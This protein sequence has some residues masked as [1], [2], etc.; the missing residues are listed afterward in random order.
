MPPEGLFVLF[1]IFSRALLLI[2]AAATLFAQEPALDYVFF[3]E[4]VQPIF[5]AKRNGHA[6]CVTCHTHRSPPLQEL[7]PGAE[8]WNDEQSRLNFAAWSQFVVPGKPTESRMLLHPLSAEAGGDVFHA[9]GKHWA[10]QG[11]PEWQTLASWVRGQVFGGLA[12]PS[13]TGVV[14]VL[15][16][17][18]AGDN[19]HVI[20][21]ETNTV[22]G[23]I[24]G[25]E[26]PHGIAIAPDGKR[27]YVTNEAR[28]TLDV[29]D[30]RTLKVFKQIP[31]SGH[32]NNVA[33]TP[34]GAKVYVAI[35]EE[36][37]GAVDVIDAVS[38]TNINRVATD[39][40]IHNVYVTPDGAQVFAGSIQT[41]VIN[42]IDVERDSIAWTIKMDAGI[43]PMAFTKNGD[44]STREIFVQLSDFHGF[45]IIDFSTRK[46]VRRVE[47]PDP[48]GMERET[49]GLQGSPS[50]GLAITPDQNIV[51]AT[52]K[53][54]HS[55]VA[56]SPPN[57]QCFPGRPI[58][59][60]Q[61][62]DY[63]VL[64]VIDVGSH[65]DW[66]TI[67]PDGKSLYVGVA[68]EDVTAVIDIEKLEVVAKIP[69]G[70]VP[71]RLVAGELSSR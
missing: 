29:V 55:V 30:S 3:K 65:P 2:L 43:R 28:M 4:Q 17:N 12:I 1:S 6:R 48:P 25:I 31:L 64:K 20:D 37:N 9:G 40:S 34:N 54:Y 41:G 67:T 60:G 71:K 42:V 5:L 47:L 33:V 27:I 10:T 19:I 32:P 69:V 45:A 14:R 62:C 52:S 49:E 26:V 46:E 38:L 7:S 57:A 44:G 21:P 66:L 61:R 68:G 53:Y 16:T 50:H 35:R 15:Q 51:W 22:V 13:T 24:Q 39:G 63:E 11:D 8:T 23:M 70:N 59:E 36:D 18:S 58:R 56:F